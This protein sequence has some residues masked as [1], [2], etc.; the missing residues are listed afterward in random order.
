MPWCCSVLKLD[1]EPALDNSPLIK[2]A[3]LAV[4]K[5]FSWVTAW[6]ALLHLCLAYVSQQAVCIWCCNPLLWRAELRLGVASWF[7]LPFI[8]SLSFSHVPVQGQAWLKPACSARA[9]LGPL[10]V[11]SVLVTSSVPSGEGAGDAERAGGPAV[12]RHTGTVLCSSS[13]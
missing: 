13:F 5:G 10:S 11:T 6:L 12:P 2:Y 9:P 4:V 1:S 3:H 7:E 8:L